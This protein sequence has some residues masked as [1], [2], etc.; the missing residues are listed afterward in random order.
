MIKI[1]LTLITIFCLNNLYGTDIHFIGDSHIYCCFT[2]THKMS[3]HDEISIFSYNYNNIPVMMIPFYFHCFPGRTMFRV[4][5]DGNNLK[6]YGIKQNDIVVY[7]FGE[8]DVR[9]HIGK[10]RDQ[11]GRQLNEV[12]NT[13]VNSY[14]NTIKQDLNICKLRSCIIVSVMPPTNINFAPVHPF[15]GPLED[16]IRITQ[17]LNQ[18]LKKYC[19]TNNFNFL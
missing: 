15:Y 17:A 18:E 5:R 1:I 19:D 11:N 9:R 3:I 13:L 16:R 14:I 12:I 8:I 4:G 2:N 7:M 10:Q 6:D